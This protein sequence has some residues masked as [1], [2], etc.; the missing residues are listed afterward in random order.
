M[1]PVHR[2]IDCPVGPT[3]V[4]I[5]L[6]PI[7]KMSTCPYTGTSGLKDDS[8]ADD[9]TLDLFRREIDDPHARFFFWRMT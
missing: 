1:I 4:L 5:T 9:T 8:A 7:M 6:D 3:I 2:F